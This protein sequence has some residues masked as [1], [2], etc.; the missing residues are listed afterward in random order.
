MPAVAW[1][2]APKETEARPRGPKPPR[3]SAERRASRVMIRL[4]GASHAPERFSAL[5]PP[6]DFGVSEA[7]SQTP[8]ANASRERDGLFDIVKWND[9][10]RFRDEP[11]FATRSPVLILRSARAGAIPQTR[12]RVR[13]SRRMRTSQCV[14][15]HASRR[16][17]ARVGRG[18]HLRLRRAAMLL[19][20]R[21]RGAP[22]FGET[23]PTVILVKRTQGAFGQTKPSGEYACLVRA[24][25]QPAAVRNDRRGRFIV[26][27]C[28]LQ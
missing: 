15:P 12:T 4:T 14:R 10:E 18:K 6:L 13:A 7:K 26:S 21:A 8:D 24:N 27:D 2:R 19:S 20:M 22:R 1:R 23:N 5:R 3:W 28:Y 16:I 25:D 9:G 11:Q 17:A